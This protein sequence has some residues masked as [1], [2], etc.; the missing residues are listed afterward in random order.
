LLRQLV[1]F[2]TKDR[3]GLTAVPMQAV[4]AKMQLPDMIA[5][6]AYAASASAN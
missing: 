6:A 5:V 3:A 1:A 4:V 2:Q